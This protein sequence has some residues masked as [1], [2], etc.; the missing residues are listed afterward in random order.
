MP[1]HTKDSASP[2]SQSITHC[3]HGSS[4]PQPRILIDRSG[5]VLDGC[6]AVKAGVETH[7]LADPPRGHGPPARHEAEE[8][9][10]RDVVARAQVAEDVDD[11]EDDRGDAHG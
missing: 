5:R 6:R 11:G 1:W 2:A 8:E 4:A 7:R 10:R 9:E 3:P